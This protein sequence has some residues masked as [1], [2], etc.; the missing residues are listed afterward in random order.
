M[1]EKFSFVSKSSRGSVDMM[2]HREGLGNH[3]KK[4]QIWSIKMI[5]FVKKFQKKVA[6]SLKLEAKS[7]SEMIFKVIIGPALSITS[8]PVSRLRCLSNNNKKLKDF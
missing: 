1:S 6:A 7:K 8:T 3:K 4:I 5:V 2:V